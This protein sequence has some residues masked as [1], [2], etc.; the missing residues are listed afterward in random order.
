MELEEIMKH[1]WQAGFADISE[2][3]III[4]SDTAWVQKEALE[5]RASDIDE[6]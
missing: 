2:I 3:M 1:K 5:L 4:I 6:R